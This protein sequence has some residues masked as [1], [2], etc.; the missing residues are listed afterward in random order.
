MASAVGL[1]SGDLIANGR[2][3]AKRAEV[4]SLADKGEPIVAMKVVLQEMRYFSEYHNV[5]ALPLVTSTFYSDPASFVAQL[6]EINWPKEVISHFCGI[7]AERGILFL[8]LAQP[9]RA[10]PELAAAVEFAEDIRDARVQEALEQARLQVSAAQ[11]EKRRVEEARKVPVTI[12]TGFLGAG[13]T[14][15][16]NYILRASHGKK[17]AVIEN[18]VGQTGIDNQLLDDE[19]MSTR[20]V[21]TVTLLDNGCLCCTVRSDLIGAVKK[22]LDHVDLVSSNARAGSAS[23]ADREEDNG[24]LLDG[25]LIE[26]TGLAD[27]GPVCKTFFADDDLRLRTRIDGVLTLVD[28]KH[29]L[30]Q[31]RRTRSDGSVNESAQQVAFADKL[32]LNKVDVVDEQTLQRIES[33]IRNINNVCSLVRCSL[34]ANPDQVP[35]DELISCGSFSLDR[36]L[37]DIAEP[38]PREPPLKRPKGSTFCQ[39]FQ[40]N[41]SRHDTGVS[42]CAITLDGAPVVLERFMQVM[43]SIRKEHAVDLYRYKGLICVKESSG[44]L[45]RAVMQG[46]HDM[47]MLEPRGGWPSDSPFVSELVFIGR[48]LNETLWSRL[49]EKTK[50]GVLDR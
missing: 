30:E 42:T 19:A 5:P 27:P 36:V 48:N 23:E 16:L 26:T 40:P 47:C 6:V 22:I 34:F 7:L 12:L 17:Y 13:K 45:K 15:L 21:E 43:N 44:C 29:F 41:R 39:D 38:E 11:V 24:T 25:I 14:T 49:F 4:R 46:V 10:L 20:T 50:E 18:E 9:S 31:L 8:A 37:R 33:E 1:A 32:L 3:A 28:A 35:L 2:W